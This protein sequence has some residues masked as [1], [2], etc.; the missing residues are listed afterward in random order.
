MVSEIGLYKIKFNGGYHL[1]RISVQEG[2]KVFK[3]D[4]GNFEPMERLQNTDEYLEIISRINERYISDYDIFKPK[5]TISWEDKDQRGFSMSVRDL[6]ALR[7]I[8]LELPF[9]Q[10]PFQYTP[11]KK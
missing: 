11:K 7:N 4:H 5:I 10:R 2:K 6:W 9:L 1:L 8:L 3:I